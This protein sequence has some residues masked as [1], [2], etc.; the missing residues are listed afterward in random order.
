MK[1]LFLF[2]VASMF[3]GFAFG[4]PPAAGFNFGN[5]TY[6]QVSDSLVLNSLSDRYGISTYQTLT[7]SLGTNDYIEENAVKN[8]LAINGYT[9][10]YDYNPNSQTGYGYSAVYNEPLPNVP[11]TKLTFMGLDGDPT[12]A[13]DVYVLTSEY[14]R[15]SDQGQANSIDKLTSGLNSEMSARTSGDSA[16]QSQIN[17]VNSR[18]DADERLKVMPEAAVRVIDTKYLSVVVYDDYDATNNRN[19][20]VGMR[21]TLKLGKSYEETRID[22][23]SRKIKGLEIMVNRLTARGK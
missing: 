13:Q 1:K 23:Q 6:G 12:K 21:Y 4:E 17:G 19:Y 7:Q 5:V 15:L 2:I 11:L 9:K 8:Q 20:A 14:N 10:A 3:T 16:L 18:L 22:E